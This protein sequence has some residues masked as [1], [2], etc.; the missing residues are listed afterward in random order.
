MTSLA[1]HQTLLSLLFAAGTLAATAPG[2]STGSGPPPLKLPPDIVYAREGHADSAV[3]FSHT[4]HVMFAGDRCTGCHPALFPMLKRGPAPSHAAMNAGGSCGRCH[5]GTQ[6]FGV[7]DSSA[8]RTCHAGPRTTRVATAATPGAPGAPAAPAEP[9]AP[10]LPKPHVYPAGDDSPGRVTFRHETHAAG[11]CASCHPKPF[12]MTAAPPLT[13]FG[14]HGANACGSC[15]DG[16]KAF[17]AEDPENCARCHRG[18]GG[19][20]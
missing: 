3:T 5:E 12:K 2:G 8:C 9:A 1:V 4:T 17:A 15:H 19:G 10:R 11:G 14:M 6:A 13:D 20:S 16:G 7:A 18:N